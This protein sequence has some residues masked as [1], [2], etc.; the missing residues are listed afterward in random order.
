MMAV[1]GTVWATQ[2]CFSFFRRSCL[3]CTG[4]SNNV[5]MGSAEPQLC[6][7]WMAK[8]WQERQEVGQTWEALRT[9]SFRQYICSTDL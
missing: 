8:G 4:A 9:L 3:V 7:N 5:C 1:G 6:E 2:G